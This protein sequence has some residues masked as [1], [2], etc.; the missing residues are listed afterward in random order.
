VLQQGCQQQYEQQQE[1]QQ[2]EQQQLQQYFS[3][4]AVWPHWPCCGAGCL[5]SRMHKHIM[6]P[7]ACKLLELEFCD[8]LPPWCT[9]TSYSGSQCG[10]RRL[11]LRRYGED[12]VT[13]KDTLI[14]IQK[15]GAQQSD[16]N[17]TSPASLEPTTSEQIT[18]LEAVVEADAAAATAFAGRASNTDSAAWRDAKGL[19]STGSAA[20]SSLR[21]LDT[22]AQKDVADLSAAAVP[23]LPVSSSVPIR[24]PSYSTIK[25]VSFSST[26]SS[27]APS[28][29]K[30]QKQI[31]KHEDFRRKVE[32]MSVTERRRKL[33]ELYV[34]QFVRTS[35]AVVIFLV[36][37]LFTP[38]TSTCILP[39]CAVPPTVCH[40][41]PLLVSFA[42]SAFIAVQRKVIS[43]GVRVFDWLV[44]RVL[45][46]VPLL[47]GSGRRSQTG[48]A[49]KVNAT[50]VQGKD[51]R[52]SLGKLQSELPA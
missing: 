25:A 5:S 51:G 18:Q 50:V 7:F 43:R 36:L 40:V 48:K 47:C 38:P 13:K 24:L 11:L 52:G 30:L 32:A 37:A 34:A 45:G 4:T 39:P 23:D 31:A 42:V 9:Y 17:K 27:V 14:K 10:Y 2:Q 8:W 46:A 15:A 35:G 28:S 44:T 29:S 16:E 1:Q 41:V 3:H 12:L 22:T 19:R 20:M 21:R 6:L 26:S 49:G 33:Y